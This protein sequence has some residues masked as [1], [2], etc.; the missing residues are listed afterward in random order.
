MSI[1]GRIAVDIGFTDAYTASGVQS[2]QRISLSGATT[3][4]SG[5]IAVVSGTVG[6][7]VT[8]LNPYA[9]GYKDASGSAVTVAS[10]GRIAISGSDVEARAVDGAAFPVVVY[11]DGPVA[12]SQVPVSFTEI[13]LR[14][15]NGT[16]SYTLFLWGI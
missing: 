6:T 1:E 15:Y 9:T 12:T 5:A 16:A 13:R 8:T 10:V 7:S 4:S 14:A 3:F 11:S 2:V